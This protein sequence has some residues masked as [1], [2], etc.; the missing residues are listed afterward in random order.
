MNKLDLDISKY[1]S[2]ELCDIFNISSNIKSD[3]I[4][5]HLNTFR[6]T[7]ITDNNMSLR[8]KD[9]INKF[10]DNVSEKISNTLNLNSFSIDKSLSF[11]SHETNMVSGSSLNHPIIENPNLQA[12]INAKIYEGKNSVI[13]EYPPGY[14]NPINIKTTKHQINIDSRFRGSYYNSS[15]SNFHYSL[16]DTFRKVVNMRV[17]SF[18]IP[19]SIHAINSSNNCFTVDSS[20]V[21]ITSGNYS[22]PFTS[23]NYS[24][25]PFS[26]GIVSQ[27]NESLITQ[28]LSDISYSIDN[29]TGKS[30]LTSTTDS[31]DIYFNKDCSGNDDLSRPLPLKLG[32]N[33]G[34]RAGSYTLTP[35][36]P[37]ISEGTVCINAPRYLYLCINDYTAAGGNNFVALYNES[38][39]SPHIIGRIQYQKLLQRNGV[40]NYGADDNTFEAT[41]EYFGPVDIQKLNLQIL[42]EYGRVVD[43][44]NMDWSC[45]ISFDV[46]YD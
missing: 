25:N 4:R 6:T 44:N 38:T 18:N 22:N 12:G 39:I 2:D 9:G 19:L 43:F 42:D 11:S 36:I 5:N 29:I 3:D 32:W 40:Y 10:I 41:R 8:E 46:L 35:G 1:S 17:T 15:S 7:I 33:L 24:Q 23:L 34:Y 30:V 14:I 26:G 28:S 13:P 27:V 37:L 21:N 31:Y 20:N 16:P 45:S